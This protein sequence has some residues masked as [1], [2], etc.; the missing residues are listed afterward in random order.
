MEGTNPALQHLL[1]AIV[2]C[3]VRVNKREV[4][5]VSGALDLD[6]VGEE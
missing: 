3:T 1:G 2:A 6:K 4:R 5:M